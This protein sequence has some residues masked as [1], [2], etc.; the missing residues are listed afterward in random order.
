MIKTI[1]LDTATPELMEFISECDK[2]GFKNNNSLEAMRIEWCVDNG[3][4]WFAT[5]DKDKI[6]GISGVHPFWDGVRALFRGCQLYSIPGGL[7]KNHMNCWM[8][9][10]HLPLVIDMYWHKP[11]FVTTNINNDASGKMIKLNKLYNHLS[12][13]GFYDHL[14]DWLI[15]EVQQNV[16]ELNTDFYTKVRDELD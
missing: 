10:Y 16:W 11:I 2:L 13:K 3:G 1:T 15:Y 8:F 6:V 9:K 7:T 12:K 4:T 14:G 5:F